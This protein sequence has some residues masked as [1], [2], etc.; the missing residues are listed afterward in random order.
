MKFE[1]GF[2]VLDSTLRCNTVV[3]H[4]EL[5][6]RTKLLSYEC[7]F[8]LILAE[9]N[10]SQTDMLAFYPGVISGNNVIKGN[11]NITLMLLLYYCFC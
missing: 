8:C 6:Q 2:D 4:I 7:R 9:K 3:P 1:I 11:C 5:L 10:M